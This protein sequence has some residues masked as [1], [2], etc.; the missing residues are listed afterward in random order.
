MDMNKWIDD[1]IAAKIKKP[2]PVLSFPGIQLIDAQVDELVK[3]GDLQAK[4]QRALI[5][6]FDML[7]VVMFMDLSVE[8]EAFGSPVLFSDDEVPTVTDN[9]L[10]TEEDIDNL[11]IPAV[12]DARTGE[13]VK[14]VAETVKLITDR[15]VFAGAIGPFSLAGR[16]LDMTEI[17]IKSMTEPESVIK[18]LE[19]V[20]EFLI[21]YIKAFKEAGA[22]GVVIAEPA[23]GLLSP[24]LN[25]EF[26][27]PYNKQI[28]DA[29]QD[30]S[31]IVIYHN[32]GNVDPLIE[33]IL[34][35]GAKAIHLGNSTKLEDIL[36][37]IPGDI[38]LMGNI[39]PSGQFR[40]GTIE[41]ITAETNELL[42]KCAK[43][44]NFVLSSGCDIPPQ[45][46]LENISAFFE[47]ADAFYK[48]R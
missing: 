45:S 26:S 12:G 5:D 7:A 27:V 29:L 3:D 19:K 14:G 39:D 35:I 21:K 20:T 16:L 43:Y 41:S 38:V 40:H 8:A 15:P 11:K 28:V 23:A 22:H 47:A 13:Y 24:Q 25:A 9:I 1:L 31:F 6:R 17:M 18:V 42:S 4:C 33:D 10:K 32:C 48:N 30:E 36:P 37:K 34:T 2:M 46:S 44:D